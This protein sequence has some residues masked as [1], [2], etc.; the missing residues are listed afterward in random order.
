MLNLD[1]GQKCALIKMKTVQYYNH[2]IMPASIDVH[3][4]V[5]NSPLQTV[6]VCV[7]RI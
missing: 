2:G 5:M 7:E 1:S 4:N 3:K 6:Q